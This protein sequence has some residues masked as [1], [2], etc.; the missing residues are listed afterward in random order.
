[1]QVH[2]LE[3]PSK[4]ELGRKLEKL[5]PDILM[6][7]GERNFERDEI[8]GLVLRDGKAITSECVSTYLSAKVPELVSVTI[9]NF[10]REGIL[11]ASCSGSSFLLII[12]FIRGRKNIHYMTNMIST[13]IA[14]L[15]PGLPRDFWAEVG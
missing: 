11:D 15:L 13:L 2:I 1:M 8:G 14:F 5:R 4:E 6:L 7:H 12:L 9:A 10:I 3:D